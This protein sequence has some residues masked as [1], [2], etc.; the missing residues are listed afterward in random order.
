MMLLPLDTVLQ[1]LKK[2]DL[3][4]TPY[5]PSTFRP[6]IFLQLTFPSGAEVQLGNDIKAN[7]GV[8]EPTVSFTAEDPTTS[9][10]TYTLV[11]FDPD[12]PSRQDQS[13]G[14]WRHLIRGGFK[15]RSLD[16]IAESG[17]KGSL[18]ERREEELL[19]PWVGPS[20]GEGTGQHR[21]VFLLYKQKAA[22][23]SMEEQPFKSNER[24]DRR[25]FD[26]A[27]F[28]EKNEL[29]LVGANFFMCENP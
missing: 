29:E 18:V 11:S 9:D 14:P 22:L 6:S 27:A 19:T 4:G 16:Q 10:S 8:D 15:P 25:N 12:A 26:V 7:Q 1:A 21:Y 2:A 24:I 13:K 28:V 3:V 23:K 20:P 5:I 17:V